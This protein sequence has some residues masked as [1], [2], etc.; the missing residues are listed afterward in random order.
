MPKVIITVGSLTVQ[1]SWACGEMLSILSLD[2]T[3]GLDQGLFE[4]VALLA[5]A[6]MYL[7]MLFP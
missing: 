6:S 1:N 4:V 2:T 5:A 3:L 7:R